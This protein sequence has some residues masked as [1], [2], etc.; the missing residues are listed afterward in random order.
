MTKKKEE[1]VLPNEYFR[2]VIERSRERKELCLGDITSDKIRKQYY[3]QVITEAEKRATLYE[4]A[5]K[6]DR[7]SVARYKEELKRPWGEWKAGLDAF[8][9][10]WSPAESEAN[11]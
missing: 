9:K 6:S 3:A 10:K 1:P 8:F 2:Q 5:A 7:E 11:P 4:G